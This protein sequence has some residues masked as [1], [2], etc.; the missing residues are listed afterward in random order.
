ISGIVS[1]NGATATFTPSG[2]L[3][4]STAYTARITKGVKDSAGN[5]LASD[6]TWSFTTISALPTPTIT[7]T[8]TATATP[9][10]TE[11]ATAT[12]TPTPTPTATA[13]PVILTGNIAGRVTDAVTGNGINGAIISTEGQPVA[14]T[15]TINGI[16]GAYVIQDIS[17]GEYTLTASATG[18]ETSSRDVTVESGETI[19]ANFALEPVTTP[20][21]TPTPESCDVATEITS[22]S[23]TVTLTKGNSTEVTVTVT[24]ENGYAV[25]NDKA[26]ARS[27]DT[28]IATVSPTKGNSTEV[29]VTVTGENGC[30]VVNDKVKASSN[31]TS[32]ATVSPSKAKTNANGQATFTITGNK[33]GSAKVTFK[34]TTANLKTK[35]TVNVIKTAQM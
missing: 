19:T 11:T 31:D 30:A 27:N 23:S 12:P 33:K 15:S 35:T 34:E 26:K 14:T 18:Y 32:I 3:S 13:T 9:T 2:N 25:V 1:Y 21:V 4:D 5:A 16:T 10:P 29:T 28:S 17:V 22:S 7:P 20:T 6:Y 24:G 8:N